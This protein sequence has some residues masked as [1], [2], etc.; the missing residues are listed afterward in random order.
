LTSTIEVM[1]TLTVPQIINCA[2]CGGTHKDLKFVKLRVPHGSWTHWTSCLTNG[3]PIML[4]DTDVETPA[5]KAW[6]VVKARVADFELDASLAEA[7][8]EIDASI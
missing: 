7:V 8:E 3:E 5:T 6:A 4:R 1:P 2:R